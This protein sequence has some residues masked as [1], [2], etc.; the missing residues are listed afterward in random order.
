MNKHAT[1]FKIVTAF[2]KLVTLFAG[3]PE[4]NSSAQDLERAIS[5]Y[6]TVPVKLFHEYKYPGNVTAPQYEETLHR[7]MA[8]IPADIFTDYNE[9]YDKK[10]ADVDTWSDFSQAQKNDTKAYMADRRDRVAK[11]LSGMTSD[12]LAAL[13]EYATKHLGTAAQT[14]L[15]HVDEI[16]KLNP[17]LSAV[18]SDRHADWFLLGAAYGYAPEEIDYFC[19]THMDE[20]NKALSADEAFLNQLG[21]QAGYKLRPDRMKKITDALRAHMLLNNK[22]NG[23]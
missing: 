14:I 3:A 9:Y 2:E 12:E 18:N 6:I 19:N 11:I 17:E 23:Q 16:K 20:R 8:L 22:E 13:F 15:Q 1:D 5:K 10:I 4:W 7:M 21:I